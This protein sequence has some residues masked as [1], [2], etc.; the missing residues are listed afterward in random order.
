MSDRVNFKEVARVVGM[1]VWRFS[2][3]LWLVGLVGCNSGSEAIRLDGLPFPGRVTPIERIQ[4]RSRADYTV[5]LKGKVGDRAPLFNGQVYQLQDSTGTIWVLTHDTSLQTG[6]QVSIRGQVRYQS[7][8]LAGQEQGE[9]YIE[10]LS[11]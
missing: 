3:L 7:I 2:I 8:P 9:F 4:T 10:E 5:R 11:Q 1:E 6:E